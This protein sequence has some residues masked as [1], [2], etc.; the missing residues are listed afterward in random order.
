MNDTSAYLWDSKSSVLETENY[1]SS[2][3]F[4]SSSISLV[5]DPARPLRLY[6]RQQRRLPCSFLNLVSEKIL[7]GG[8]DMEIN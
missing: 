8:L 2:L 1:Q 4:R 3:T 6:Q 5:G 7:L